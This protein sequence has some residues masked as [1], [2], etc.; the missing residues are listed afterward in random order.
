MCYHDYDFQELANE[1]ERLEDIIL[2]FENENKQL[3][4]E[5]D[6]LKMKNEWEI[7]KIN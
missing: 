6:I 7:F 4:N 2:T 3:K 1:I 5:N